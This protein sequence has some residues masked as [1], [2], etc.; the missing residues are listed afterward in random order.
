MVRGTAGPTRGM[1]K[2]FGDYRV[3]ERKEEDSV[4]NGGHTGDDE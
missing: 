4:I 1:C 2:M 3:S